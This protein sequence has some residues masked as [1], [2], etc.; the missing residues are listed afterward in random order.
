M[1]LHG[2]LT[3]QT[4]DV[5]NGPVWSSLP[6]TGV[7]NVVDGQYAMDLLELEAMATGLVPNVFRPA[8]PLRLSAWQEALAD[9]PDTHQSAC[10]IPY[11]TVQSV[12]GV[13]I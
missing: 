10:I 1:N 11:L 5:A 12:Y 8:T 9:H 3:A 2:S 7:G 6:Y 13:Y 4:R